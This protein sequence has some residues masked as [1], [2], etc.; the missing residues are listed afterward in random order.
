MFIEKSLT[1]L[2]P[3]DR[4]LPQILRLRELLGRGIAVHHGGLLPIMKEIVEILFAKSLVKVLFATETF[5][6]GLNLPTRTV[7]FSGFRKHDGKGFRDL[8]PGEYTQMAGRAGRRGLDTVGYVIIT[9]NAGRDDAPPAG[10]LKKMILGDPTKLRSQFRLTYNMILN[11]LRVEALKIEEMIKRSF[12]ENATQALLPEHEKQVQLSEASLEK[13]KR[14]SCEVCDIDLAACHDAAM[15]YER[16]TSELHTGLLASPIGKRQFPQKKL[17]VYRKDGL[18]TAGI[19]VRDGTTNGA[20]P[21]IQVL[22]IGTIGNKR[23]PGDILPFLPKFRSL[24]QPLPSNAASMSLKVYKIPVVDLECVTNTQVK[25][26]GPAWYLNI[27]KEAKKFAE[28]ELVKYTSSWVDDRWDELDWSRVKELQVRDILDKRKAQAQIAQSCHC[29]QCPNF[30]KHFEMQHDEWQVKENISQLKQLMSDQNLQLLPDYEQRI[31]VL[32][33]LGFVDDQA[34]VQ[35]K[36]KVACEIHSADELVLTEL[37]L[38]NVLAEYEPE[39]IVA[40]LSAFVFQEKTQSTPTLTPR[41]E[42]GQA[43]IIRISE[44]VN[45]FQVLHQVIQSSEDSNDFASEPRFGL[46]EVVYEWAKGMSFNRITDLTDVMEGTIVRTI[47][48]LDETCREVKNAAKL[49]GDPSLY[50]KM[51]QAQELIKRDVIFAASLYM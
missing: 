24:L 26:G 10:A 50:T 23:H 22:E 35:L 36:G 37:I 9:N 11:L 17:V 7:V 8:L 51:Q 18:R 25:A 15:E 5:A 46:A 49:V 27:K 20:V 13:I 32:K 2:K 39:E 29:L 1:R 48:R 45:D 42:K 34:R 47:T 28:K 19:I 14:E 43:A 6:M 31:Q 44:K 40:L 21:C 16:L 33:E 38:E 4:T 3:E 30:L 41:L 12:S